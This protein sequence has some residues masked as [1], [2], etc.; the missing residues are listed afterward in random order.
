MCSLLTYFALAQTDV[1]RALKLKADLSD[2]QAV[3]S[4]TATLSQAKADRLYVDTAL[5]HKCD[6]VEIREVA[7]P[8]LWSLSLRALPRQS[9]TSR[10]A[11]QAMA[12]TA[13][14]L[15]GLLHDVAGLKSESQREVERLHAIVGDKA[16]HNDLTTLRGSFDSKGEWR[17]ALTLTA[18][19]L[20]QDISLK[21]QS[22]NLVLSLLLVM[23]EAS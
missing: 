19:T 8:L 17:S 1:T 12:R 18:Q 3:D 10:C 7:H 16:S 22:P 20:Q 13:K 9:L 5:A 4:I 11:E 6:A 21:V 15:A 23:H 14:S 2:L